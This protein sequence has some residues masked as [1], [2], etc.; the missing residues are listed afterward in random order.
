MEGR[1]APLGVV[2]HLGAV[3]HDQHVHP[4]RVVESGEQLGC[5]EE[6]LGTGLVA[7][8]ADQQLEHLP[9]IPGVHALVD[10]VHTSEGDGGELLES[11]HV[12]GSRH[13][14]GKK[15][16]HYITVHNITF[17]LLTDDAQSASVAARYPDT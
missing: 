9:L 1:H 6:V 16:L 5:E 3:I 10:L 2:T 13:T 14:P 11:Q 8:G 4:W 15:S 17:P 12:Q 7:R